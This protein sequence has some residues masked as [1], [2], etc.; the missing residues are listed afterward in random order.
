MSK[1]TLD[2]VARAA[3][4]SRATLYRA[5]PGGKDAVVRAVVETELARL[6]SELA[7]HMGE[8]GNLED[9]LVAG[10]SIASNRIAGHHALLFLLEHEP[11]IVLPHLAFSH[12]DQVLITAA[13]FAAPFLGRWLAHYE[14]VRVAEWSA[15]IVFS[16]ALNPADGIDL[17]D[18]VSARRVVRTYVLPG[19]R[20]LAA[21]A[22]LP[23]ALTA[24]LNHSQP[25]VPSAGLNAHKGEAS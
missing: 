7:V 11:E 23:S 16:Y 21:R 19:V 5:F 12:H 22:D 14:A 18:P 20:V 25:P 10:V 17:T 3:G 8:A 1:T 4:C 9:A 2:D 15:R 24:D 13:N 6:F